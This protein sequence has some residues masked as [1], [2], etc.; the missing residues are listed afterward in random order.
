M[1]IDKT[2]HVTLLDDQ[3]HITQRQDNMLKAKITINPE[4]VEGLTSQ[5]KKAAKTLSGALA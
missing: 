3:I 4:Q 5:L 1:T 2:V